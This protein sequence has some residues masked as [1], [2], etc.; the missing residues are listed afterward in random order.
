VATLIIHLCSLLSNVCLLVSCL[1]G[2]LTKAHVSTEMQQ[3]F[4]VP[5]DVTI[6]TS[7]F[8]ALN[9]ISKQLFIFIYAALWK[10]D[11]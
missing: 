6:V 8:D 5:S 2:G 3:L 9:R 1:E 11:V 10:Q 7:L 4:G